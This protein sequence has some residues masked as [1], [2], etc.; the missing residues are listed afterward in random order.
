[1]IMKKSFTRVF[2]KESLL[3]LLKSQIT[4]D[5]WQLVCIKTQIVDFL[6][7]ALVIRG[8]ANKYQSS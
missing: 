3:P 6:Y 5:M 7:E 4:L 2:T 8:P 1:M